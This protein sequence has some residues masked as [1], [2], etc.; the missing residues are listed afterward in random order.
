MSRKGDSYYSHPTSIAPWVV[1]SLAQADGLDLSQRVQVIESAL[2]QQVGDL[3]DH[4]DR[5]RNAAGPEGVPDGIDLAA[6]F[7][8]EH[9]RVGCLWVLGGGRR[10]SVRMSGAG[11]VQPKA[12]VQ[13]LG[14]RQGSTDCS[15]M[16]AGAST[17]EAKNS[18]A[19]AN[20]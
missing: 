7:A 15:L 10:A 11:W 1:N 13:L 16:A 18:A 4:L 8:G 5:I 12:S 6:Q 14:E 3:L 17:L 19:A 20:L 2:E 9:E